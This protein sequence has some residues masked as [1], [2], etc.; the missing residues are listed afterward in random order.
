M[1][2]PKIKIYDSFDICVYFCFMLN[3]LGEL[4][5]CVVSELVQTLETVNYFELMS[6]TGRMEKKELISIRQ[7]KERGERV[8]S[9]LPNGKVLAEEF[10]SHI[11]LSIQEKTEETG[12]EVIARIEREKSIHCYIN[13]DFRRDRYDLNVKFLNELNGQVILDINVF[14][15]D[16]EQAKDMKERFLSKPTFIIQRI[17]NMFLKDDFFMYDR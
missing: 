7:D 10:L 11:P 5:D 4:G 14:A 3:T 2:T 9:L 13:Y 15:P 6:E 1:E 17:M 16:E 8:Y 12:K